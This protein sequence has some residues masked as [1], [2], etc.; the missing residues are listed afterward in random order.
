MYLLDGKQIECELDVD[1]D[2]DNDGPKK[3]NLGNQMVEE[4][5]IGMMFDYEQEV[6]SYYK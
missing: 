6:L 3:I 5:K 1:D 4:P 2:E